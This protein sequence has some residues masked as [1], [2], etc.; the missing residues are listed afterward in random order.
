MENPASEKAP[1]GRLD[2]KPWRSLLG[3]AKALTNLARV[4]ARLAMGYLAPGDGKLQVK[5]DGHGRTPKMGITTVQREK[6]I[7]ERDDQIGLRGAKPGPWG[8]P[9]DVICAIA[10]LLQMSKNEDQDESATVEQD[11]NKT[12]DGEGVQGPGNE[13]TVQSSREGQKN[14]HKRSEGR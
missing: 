7:R 11:K 3:Q 10:E 13:V 5:V 1:P 2:E 8:I 6:G 14:T 9:K 4:T 12:R